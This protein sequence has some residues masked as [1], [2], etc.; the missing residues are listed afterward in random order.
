[1]FRAMSLAWSA[2]KAYRPARASSF[3][4][5]SLCSVHGNGVADNLTHPAAVEVSLAVVEGR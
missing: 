4:S 1:M 3:S 2:E 5:I